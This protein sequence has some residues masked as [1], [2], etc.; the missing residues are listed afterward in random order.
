[1]GGGS[2]LLARDVP[3]GRAAHAHALGAGRTIRLADG[4]YFLTLRPSDPATA[5]EVN[6]QAILQ[7]ATLLTGEVELDD[8]L[9]QTLDRLLALSGTERGFIMLPEQGE[10]VVK[11]AAQPLRRGRPAGRG[12]PAAHG[13]A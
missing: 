11:V 1:M 3:R 12:H 4:A 10:L 6:L 8:L 7:T 13:R 5:S 9:E 2:R